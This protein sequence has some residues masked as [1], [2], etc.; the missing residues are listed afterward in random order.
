VPAGV[1]GAGGDRPEREQDRAEQ[2]DPR[3]LDRLL[4]LFP[5]ERGDQRHDGRRGHEEDDPEQQQR[6][7]DQRCDR[8]HDPPRPLRLVRGE[9]ARQDRHERGAQGTRSDQLEQQVREA[10]CGVE[11]VELGAQP[12]HG[13]HR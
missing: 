8:R 10:E 3:Q 7:Q 4:Q 13:G 9:Q 12:E 2:H 1:Q 6:D 11:G 5:L